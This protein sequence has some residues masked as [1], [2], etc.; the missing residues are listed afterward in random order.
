[1]VSSKAISSYVLLRSG[2]EIRQQGMAL[3]M[4]M[5]FLVLITGVGVWGVKQSIFSENVAR[6]QLDYQVAREAAETALRDAERDLLNPSTALTEHASCSRGGWEISFAEFT[7]D[8][9]KG[10]CF[11]N[12]D[13]YASLDWSKSSSG[14]VWWPRSKSGKWNNNSSEKPGRNPIAATNC[15]F[16]GGVPLGTFT[17]KA[18]LIGVARQPEYLIEYFKRKN[19]R[20]NLEETQISSLNE[21]PNQ[22]SPMYRVTA[23]GFGYSMKTQV[24]LQTVFFP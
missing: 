7:S 3:V 1:M 11:L 23:R 6:N 9:L 15:D 18:P 10:L 14:E 5:V 17:G 12:D 22:W 19:V 20:I 8:C 2:C 16:K 21:N 24:L 13:I 4:V